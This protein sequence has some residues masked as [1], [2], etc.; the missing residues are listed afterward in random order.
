MFRFIREKILPLFLE[1]EI[2]I[3]ELSKM[4]NVSHRTCQR[5][6]SGEKVSAPIVTRIC[7]ALGISYNQQAK[8]IVGA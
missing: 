8:Y 5:A 1:R 4:A 3:Y 2:T 6:I 7:K